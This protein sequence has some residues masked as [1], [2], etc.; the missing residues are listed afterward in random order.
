MHRAVLAE[1]GALLSMWL[2]S[3]TVSSTPGWAGEPG[4][5]RQPSA[6]ERLPRE[7]LLYFGF[8]DFCDGHVQN[9]LPL[10]EK[11]GFKG[12]FYTCI[13]GIRPGSPLWNKMQEMARS[14][15]CFVDHTLEHR[16][17]D[18]NET[19]NEPEWLRQ[20]TESLRLFRAAG[21]EV[22]GWWQPGGPGAKYTP[23]IRGFLQG[24]YRWAWASQPASPGRHRSLHWHFAGDLY[25]FVMGAG[26]GM[27]YAKNQADAER[28][29]RQ[30]KTS[31]ADAVAQG[32]IVLYGGHH[33]PPGIKQWG[34]KQACAYVRQAGFRTVN[35]NE[36]VYAVTHTREFYG[37][38][39]EQM[40]NATLE[41]DRDGD[42][43]P[44]GWFGCAIAP[45]GARNQGKPA[46]TVAGSAAYTTLYGPEPGENRLQLSARSASDKP[47]NVTLTV[48]AVIVG[49][50]FLD[51]PETQLFRKVYAVGKQWLPI[52]TEIEVAPRTDRLSILIATGPG[53]V[54][55]AEPSFRRVSRLGN[56]S[57]PST[58]TSL[59]ALTASAPPISGP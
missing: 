25:N 35:L 11:D 4:E 37:E 32:R 22:H 53:N 15:H 48:R 17:A 27:D 39:C 58:I 20:T 21:I 10:L 13:G 24:H 36:A 46:M 33:T 41:L 8:A 3:A 2:L 12:T 6:K 26:G 9:T 51:Q 40:P 16:A 47:T 19:P 14:G 55:V 57:Q 49:E 45:A 5:L 30:F 38:F 34:L 56:R 43:R 28:F 18:W 50:D 54:Y 1:C 44:D 29:F 7:G 52:A 31:S 42:G 59:R 23:A